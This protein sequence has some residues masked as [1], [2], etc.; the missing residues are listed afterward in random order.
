MSI[1][2]LHFPHRH[3]IRTLVVPHD[4]TG[5]ENGLLLVHFEPRPLLALLLEESCLATIKR[6]GDNLR[7]HTALGS[8]IA[9]FEFG[10]ASKAE[11]PKLF[12]SRVSIDRSSTP[13]EDILR[14]RFPNG[15][16][17]VFFGSSFCRSFC[18][19]SL[20]VWLRYS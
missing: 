5:L 15:I 11:S 6:D 19:S 13:A 1:L 17:I 14:G 10:L 7:G 16:R 3:A 20:V 8:V 4:L 18:S 9:R 12:V 2:L